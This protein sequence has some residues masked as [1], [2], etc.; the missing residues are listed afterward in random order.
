MLCCSWSGGASPARPSLSEI[1]AYLAAKPFRN[2]SQQVSRLNDL[3]QPI[4]DHKRYLRTLLYAARFLYSWETG[5]VVSNDGAVSYVE[6]RG[7]VGS[8]TD[9]IRSALQCRNEGGDPLPLF[10]E[11][12]RLHAPVNCCHRPLSAFG[13]E[14]I[15]RLLKRARYCSRLVTQSWRGTNKKNW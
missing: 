3:D 15:R 2:W 12:P 8:E 5:N 1:R 11:R 7:L 9:I 13:Q 14:E 6:Q 10:S 4:D